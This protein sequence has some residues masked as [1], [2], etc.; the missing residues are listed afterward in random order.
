MSIIGDGTSFLV[1]KSNKSREDRFDCQSKYV[2]DLLKNFGMKNAISIKAH[3]VT[4]G[5]LHFDEKEF[6]FKPFFLWLLLIQW[7]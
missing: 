5:H 7:C 2:N 6:W 1:L 4:N 3:M